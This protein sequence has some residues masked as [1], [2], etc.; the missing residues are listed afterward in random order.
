MDPTDHLRI[1]EAVPAD[2]ER[3]V[4]FNCLLAEETEGVQLDVATVTGGVAALLADATKGRY[5][6][7]E[8][9]N[10][11][12]QPNTGDPTSFAQTSRIVGQVLITYEWSDWRNG[13]VW[14]VQSVYVEESVRQQ[15]VFRR[16]F[17]HLHGLVQQDPNV[18]GLRLYV[19]EHNTQA[20]ETY[21]RVGF[22]IAPYQLMQLLKTSY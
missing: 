21:R 3:I 11:V 13:Q 17:A 2:G 5:F 9:I 20:Q 15:G 14:W 19:E 22:S 1:R 4:A 10:S 16:L 12:G 6:V 7:A 8:L 18:V